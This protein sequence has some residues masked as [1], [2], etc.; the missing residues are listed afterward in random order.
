MRE[1]IFELQPVFDGKKNEF[2]RLGDE[3]H[4]DRDDYNIIA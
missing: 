1:K 4:R 2:Q 3:S